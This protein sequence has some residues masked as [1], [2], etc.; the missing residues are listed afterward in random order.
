METAR[1]LL[2]GNGSAYLT[3]LGIVAALVSVMFVF[4][5]TGLRRAE[6]AG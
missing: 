6:A 2:A 3:T 4:A 1:D 5:I